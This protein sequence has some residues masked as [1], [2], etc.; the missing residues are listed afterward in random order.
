MK[1]SVLTTKGW[2]L[3]IVA[4]VLVAAGTLNFAQRL[5]HKPP[6]TDGVQWADTPQGVVAVS[7]EPDSA[8][9]TGRK[10]IFA[11]MPG[12][13]LVGIKS[14]AGRGRRGRLRLRR[15]DLP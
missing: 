10:G 1:S 15:S 4:A 12:D 5:T 14:D 3:L 6:P 11:I 13:L 2:A 8:A 9:G 7:V